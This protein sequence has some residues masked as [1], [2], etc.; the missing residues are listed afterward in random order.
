MDA[1]VADTAGPW[2]LAEEADA[3]HPQPRWRPL[4]EGTAIN[5]LGTSS[6]CF[7]SSTLHVLCLVLK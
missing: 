4:C 5:T 7:V 2:T 1:R 3:S 6:H